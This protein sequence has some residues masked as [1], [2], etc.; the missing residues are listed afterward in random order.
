ME[1]TGKGQRNDMTVLRRVLFWLFAIFAFGDAP[2]GASGS[3]GSS[4]DRWSRV[5]RELGSHELPTRLTTID[6]S[7]DLIDRGCHDCSAREVLAAGADD[8]ASVAFAIPSPIARE[9]VTTGARP[10]AGG[11][12]QSP[13]TGFSSRA[14]PV[15]A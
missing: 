6:E 12:P 10:T 15:P 11:D 5:S 7:L 9:H 13:A 3:F 8:H 4:D 2:L 14:P 1:E